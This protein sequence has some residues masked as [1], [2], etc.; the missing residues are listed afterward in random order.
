M[1]T[2]LQQY[3][4]MH[5]YHKQYIL[6]IPELPLDIYI[7]LAKKSHESWKYMINIPVF[8]RWTLTNEGKLIAKQMRDPYIKIDLINRPPCYLSDAYIICLRTLY[9]NTLHSFNNFPS[10]LEI[11]CQ[12]HNNKLL[13]R[14]LIY[15]HHKMGELYSPT[16]CLLEIYQNDLKNIAEKLCDTVQAVMF[17]QQLE[18]YLKETSI[19][20]MTI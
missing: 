16:L 5:N 2:I 19:W 9:K 17:Q 15:A 8:G 4:D 3:I 11:K 1:T 7:E 14:N 18:M 12:R 6:T 20:E 13:F 10:F